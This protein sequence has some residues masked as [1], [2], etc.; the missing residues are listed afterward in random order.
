MHK[1]CNNSLDIIQ[2]GNY[3]INE[4]RLNSKFI[5]NPTHTIIP[6]FNTKSNLS[7]SR[8]IIPTNLTTK[9]KHKRA[10][11]NLLETISHNLS[12]QKKP[13]I[14]SIDHTRH[15]SPI[16]K[17][18]IQN[19]K[20]LKPERS[21]LQQVKYKISQTDQ[22]ID[23]K[24]QFSKTYR[25]HYLQNENSEN[26]VIYSANTKYGNSINRHHTFKKSQERYCAIQRQPKSEK[27]AFDFNQSSSKLFL[28]KKFSDMCNGSILDRTKLTFCSKH[29]EDTQ[30]KQKPEDKMIE[31][32]NKFFDRDKT[33]YINDSCQQVVTQR[34][35]SNRTI[36]NDNNSPT[37]DN[38]QNQGTASTVKNLPVGS[39]KKRFQKSSRSDRNSGQIKNQQRK[40]NFEQTYDTGNKDILENVVLNEKGNIAEKSSERSIHIT[41]KANIL[42]E[43]KKEL[44]GQQHF[45]SHN[46]AQKRIFIQDE[47]PEAIKLSNLEQFLQRQTSVHFTDRKSQF[48]QK[49]SHVSGTTETIQKLSSK[50][51]TSQ[52]LDRNT[53]PKDVP[54]QIEGVSFDRYKNQAPNP[55]KSKDKKFRSI[56][57]NN[58]GDINIGLNR[59]ANDFNLT[60]LT[61]ITDTLPQYVERIKKRFK[62]IAAI[63]LCDDQIYSLRVLCLQQ[64][65]NK[66]QFKQTLE[67]IL[68]KTASHNSKLKT[69][70][71]FVG[72]SIRSSEQFTLQL[73][74]SNLI[75]TSANPTESIQDFDLLEEEFALLEKE[76]NNHIEKRKTAQLNVLAQHVSNKGSNYQNSGIDGNFCSKD[77]IKLNKFKK[78]LLQEDNGD[79]TRYVLFCQILKNQV[80][81][82][83][84]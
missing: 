46:G 35:L 61:E 25:G 9:A 38:L 70:I 58:S 76:R 18:K 3:F 8:S 11:S 4:K 41:T 55:E 27:K 12:H 54:I 33:S 2:N 66:N 19:S 82:F 73:L 80:E 68:L 39:V 57:K 64:Q 71:L 69:N 63:N 21:L 34:S 28:L 37:C 56:S 16:S 72:N 78:L 74:L 1:Q 42:N 79:Y 67:L 84:Q 62:L 50:D 83:P 14:C 52:F 22:N 48:Q 60:S 23:Q 49:A 43:T 36:L 5:I 75:E 15:N 47:E 81:L 77:V 31:K 53:F 32:L 26:E 40:S 20:I 44:S 29:D 17:L 51:S 45:T 6:N 7:G 24:T 59:P 10:F 13:E 30:P 65:D